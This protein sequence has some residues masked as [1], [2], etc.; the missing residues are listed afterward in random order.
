[1]SKCKWGKERK[2]P[3]L[4]AMCI[5][6]TLNIFR[7]QFSIY[8]MVMDIWLHFISIVHFR[9]YTSSVI[10]QLSI[11]GTKTNSHYSIRR[12][13]LAEQVNT[14]AKLLSQ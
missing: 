9:Q 11:F 14:L 12:L 3:I 13:G 7:N 2:V 5:V 1:M 8:K 6:D 4:R 10:T